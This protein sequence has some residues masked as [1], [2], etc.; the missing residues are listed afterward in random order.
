MVEEKKGSVDPNAEK[1]L[2]YE[3]A[4]CERTYS[5]PGMC[6]VCKAVL[7]PKGE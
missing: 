2:V 6:Q 3:C 7:K 5:N 1:E 4:V